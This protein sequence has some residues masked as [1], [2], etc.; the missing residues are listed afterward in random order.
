[1]NEP[2]GSATV[3]STDLGVSNKPQEEFYRSSGEKARQA[4][5][6]GEARKEASKQGNA[7]RS[8]ARRK[9][10]GGPECVI[11]GEKQRLPS[12]HLSS[13]DWFFLSSPNS[14]AQD[15]YLLEYSKATIKHGSIIQGNFPLS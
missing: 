4:K 13:F 10:T 11:H 15:Q 2:E 7:T 14:A 3:G 5:S 1:M 8:L 12:S 6:E 9:R